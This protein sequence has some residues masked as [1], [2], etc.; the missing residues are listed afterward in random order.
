MIISVDVV[1]C[2]AA[3]KLGLPRYAPKP[4]SPAGA[5]AKAAKSHKTS[6]VGSAQVCGSCL[7]YTVQRYMYTYIYRH[8]GNVRSGWS[9]VWFKL[10]VA[11]RQEITIFS[12]GNWFLAGALKEVRREWLKLI[13]II[14]INC[15]LH[16]GVVDMIYWNTPYWVVT[17]CKTM[18]EFPE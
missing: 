15:H 6:Y 12:Q 3:T 13:C 17:D 1:C 7:P 10:G 11:Q 4:A 2:C 14:F 18:I 9:C 16:M 5:I 8:R